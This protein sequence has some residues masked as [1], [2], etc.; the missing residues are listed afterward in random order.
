MKKASGLCLIVV[1]LLLHHLSVLGGEPSIDPLKLLNEVDQLHRA[2]SS[3]ATVSME[4]AN[5]DYR[6]TMK[7]HAWSLGKDYTLIR[8]LHPKKDKGI[9]TL[10]KARQMWN[11]LPKVKRVIMI[12]PS[13]MMGKWMG[14]DFTNDDLVKQSELAEDYQVTLDSSGKHHRLV[15]VPKKGVA[16]VWG[17][18]EILVAKDTRLPVEQSYFNEKGEKVRQLIF[19]DVRRFGKKR[20]PAKMEMRSL[21]K[22][23]HYTVVRYDD[24]RFDVKLTPEFFSQNNLKRSKLQ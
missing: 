13:M 5:K 1:S 21:K 15:L 8:I 23:G 18:M 19:S 24:L 6:R 17:R 7:L 12:P 11:Y 4:V 16:T 2:E 20:L 9:S 22:P 3:K 10:R 14:S